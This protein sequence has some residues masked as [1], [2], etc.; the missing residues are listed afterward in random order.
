MTPL[1]LQATGSERLLP[2]P[3]RRTSS[4]ALRMIAAC[5]VRP[6]NGRS[7]ELEL[8]RMVI[9]DIVLESSLWRP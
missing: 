6:G 2:A 7:G 5:A 4:A 3:P 8:E 1:L 9:L